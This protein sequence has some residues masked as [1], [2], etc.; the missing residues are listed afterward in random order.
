MRSQCSPCRPFSLPLP[1]RLARTA[2]L[3]PPRIRPPTSAGAGQGIP[4]L[5]GSP[6]ERAE[7]I[8]TRVNARLE[9]A[10]STMQAR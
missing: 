1:W 8:V 9:A 3:L 7:Q 10:G 2:P 4:G 6:T 5:I